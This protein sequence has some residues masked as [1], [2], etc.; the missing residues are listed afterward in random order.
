MVVKIKKVRFTYGIHDFHAE[1]AGLSVAE[2]KLAYQDIL[3]VGVD[4]E[5]YINGVASKEST[6]LQPGNRVEFMKS[7]G[8]KGMGKPSKRRAKKKYSKT[9]IPL[10]PTERR[11]I[12][13]A[14]LEEWARIVWM[15]MHNYPPEGS[16]IDAFTKLFG[17][18]SLASSARWPTAGGAESRMQR[19]ERRAYQFSGIDFWEPLDE[20]SWQGLM[21][22]SLG[23]T[24]EYPEAPL[25]GPVLNM[26]GELNELN[27]MDAL[28][29]EDQRRCHLVSEMLKA[30]LS[31]ASINPTV[32][33]RWVEM[34]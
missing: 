30:T 20:V 13:I 12:A 22:I 4:A 11:R 16:Y 26:A 3:N 15:S 33:P 9:G 25:A 29:E 8:R 6:I 10:D 19:D 32:T 5:I 31:V 18:G 27:E 14:R 2:A 1:V 23:Y 7:R 28:S 21:A 17:R 24:V 34:D